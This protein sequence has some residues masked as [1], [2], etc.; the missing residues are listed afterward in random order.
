MKKITLLF[1]LM[2]MSIGFSQ[3][4]LLQDFEA[5]G[6]DTGFS[7]IGSAGIV[8]D[9]AVGGTRGKVARLAVVAGA[10]DPWQGANVTL[11]PNVVLTTDKTIKMD[12]YSVNPIDIL[13]KVDAGL[14]GAPPSAVEVQHPG[15]SVWITK[16]IS[17]TTPRDNT[18]MN[19]NGTYPLIAVFP[20]WNHTTPPGSFY[21]PPVASEVY[22]DNIYGVAPAGATCSDGIQN[23]GETGI[24]C[25]GPCAA[26]PPDPEPTNAP[27]TPPNY[28]NTIS[29][30]GDAFGTAVPLNGVPWDSGSEAVEGSYASNNALKI[31]NGTLDFIG[32]DI[33]NANG[34]VDA[35]AMTHVHADFWIAADYVAGQVV[36]VKL[37]NHAGAIGTETSS[38]IK[39]A[40]PTSTD[41]K[42]WYTLDLPLDAGT[43]NRIAQVLIIYTN[44]GVPPKTV[45]L[46]NLYMYNVGSLS[47][48]DFEIAGLKV[49]PN[50]SQNSWTVRTQNIKMTSIQVY[51][52]L[53]KNVLSITPND[54][55][56]TINGTS[57][58]TGLYFAQIRTESGVS[59]LKL[60][61][62]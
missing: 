27:T 49:F 54:S 48:K 57:L 26:C 1:A 11:D 35:T 41:V 40:F 6:L 25:G 39:E 50:P 18:T 56:A 36:K 45:F 62:Q 20:N 13:V 5:G 4:V 31:T 22:F 19:A 24:D 15:G 9:P 33:G 61:K 12:I 51:D 21:N 58:R 16:T 52:M 32:F 8:D 3:Q 23:Q 42:K 43:R 34:F 59:S 55:E 44:S 60:I 38:I 29:L 10:G 7:G 47:S 14:A 37:S 46:D 53:G 30:Y 2:A 17:F 28:T